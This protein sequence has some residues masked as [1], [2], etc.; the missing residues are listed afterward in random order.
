M[1]LK[2]PILEITL[3]VDAQHVGSMIVLC[4]MHNIELL[5]GP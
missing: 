1:V 4:Y 2:L 5:W 3:Q